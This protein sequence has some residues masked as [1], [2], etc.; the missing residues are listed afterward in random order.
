MAFTKPEKAFCV[1]EFVKTELWT[2]VQRA[3]RTKFQKEEPER[4]SILRWHGKFMKDGCLCPAKRMGRPQLQMI[5]L[6]EFELPSSR[7]PVNRSE[8]PVGNFSFLQQLIGVS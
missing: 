8:E 3:F 6:S 1:L 5:R 2:F 7:A 4:K